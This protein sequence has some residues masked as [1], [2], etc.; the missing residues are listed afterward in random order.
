MASVAAS[1]GE[2]NAY[3][4]SLDLEKGDLGGGFTDDGSEDDK[5]GIATSARGDHGTVSVLSVQSGSVINMET[6]RNDARFA[7]IDGRGQT[8]VVIDTGMDLDNPAFGPDAN[9]DGI[10]DRI[11]FS[12][13]FTSE[14]DGTAN[15][16]EGHGTHVASIIGSSSSNTLGVAPGVNFVA[17]QA[18]DATGSGT[19]A[20]I[21]D[22]LQWVVQN[23]EAMNI[24]AVNM[25]LGDGSNFNFST[26]HPAYGDELRILHDNLNVTVVAAAG[27]DYD[28]YQTEG[29]SSLAVD[30]HAIAIGAVGGTVATGSEIAFFS[31]RSDDI[32]TFFAPGQAI[33][34]AA[35][36][37]GTSASSG[38]SQAAPHVAGMIAL[39]QQLAQREL[40]RSLT[41]DEMVS[42]L[43]QSGTSFVDDENLDDR[44]VNTGSTYLRVD[45][46]NF[47]EA[48]LALSQT[49][50]PAPTPGPTPTPT[51]NPTPVD[52][53]DGSI[54]TDAVIAVNSTRTSSID[55]DGDLDYFAISLTP[56]EY[57]FSLRASSSGAGSLSDPLL[58][59]VSSTGAFISSDDD[60]GAG[61]DSLLNFIVTSPATFF[62]GAGAFGSA[63]GSYELG[64][65]QLSGESGDVGDTIGTAG[66]LA[67]GETTTSEIDFGG[68]R[69]WFA[70]N[71]VNGTR[72]TFDLVGNTLPDPYLALYNENGTVVAA[73]DDGGE[74]LNASLEFV[75]NRTGTF[76]LSAE[77]FS[78]S[79]T[80]TYSLS[81]AQGS[82]TGDDYAEGPN[83]TGAIDAVAGTITGRLETAGDRDWFRVDLVAGSTYEF[84]LRGADGAQGLSDPF[85][86]LFDAS[87]SLV[88]SNDDSSQGL[89]SLLTF[90]AQA[91]GSYFLAAG[92][93][94]DNGTGDY[95]LSSARI[96]E[97]QNDVPGN[98]SSTATLAVGQTI[99]GAIDGPGDFDWYGVNTV[100]GQVYQ[101]SLVSAGG[102]P[103]SDPWLTL[104]DGA[105]NFIDFN[106]DGPSGTDS[107]LEYVA[108]TG[109]RVFISAEPYDLEADVGTYELSLTSPEI[110]P[111]DIPGN[112]STQATLF[113]GQVA[114]GVIDTPG[115]IDWYRVQLEAGRTYEFTMNSAGSDPMDD[116]WL[117]LY[118]ASGSLIAFD[119]DSGGGLNSLLQYQAVA[120]ETVYLS[121]EAFDP[122]FDE[123]TYE[124]GVSVSG[125][126][127]V[128]DLPAN[129]STPASL[130]FDQFVDGLIDVPG[131]SDWYAANLA[132]GET[133]FFIMTATGT[134][135][136]LA[137]P[138]LVLYDSL[139][140]QI[141]EDDDAFGNLDA[142]IEYTPFSDQRV[143]ISAQAFSPSSDSGSYSIGLV[144]AQTVFS[145]FD[146]I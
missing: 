23:A 20:G 4:A 56:G 17:L 122:N 126:G 99:S 114:A 124:V 12:R 14:G 11:I 6:F 110:R 86:Y 15:D 92:A 111:F 139:G 121:A 32:P 146:V 30:P 33:T 127:P 9:N 27:N 88:G 60:S 85:L 1:R 119:D 67:V 96:G 51:P 52:D 8:V 98:P 22:A 143:Y 117:F 24:V 45:A 120:N 35:P 62:L 95:T 74:G 106:D 137:D 89:D 66:R 70:I 94:A 129:P 112:Q 34:G 57:E 133:Y 123:G 31:Q 134:V 42:L 116:T 72:Y 91:G 102:D 71:L 28:F 128:G 7:G 90:N 5:V 93:F 50:A 77:G 79:Q 76:Y 63:T 138:Y 130:S 53:I 125:S 80:G 2:S 75:A 13:D 97:G 49:G 135:G 115:D 19:V 104:Y 132:G 29:A 25:S 61:L 59:V 68:D 18:L 55:F 107:Y 38:T 81:A 58:T 10:A 103:M 83:T 16:V 145:E 48:M 131:D 54:S 87:G 39:A 37:G 101:F 113:L 142:M 36:G 82:S 144:T 140:N 108:V 3:F 40:G 73:N 100:A 84:Q 47:G 46:F 44:V 136:S 41:P 141:T 43:R 78:P 69:D 118:D 105:G 21:E 65:A 109:G 64:V 26:S